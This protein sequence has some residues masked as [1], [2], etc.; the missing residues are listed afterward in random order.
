MRTSKPKHHKNCS[1][2]RERETAAAAAA[3]EAKRL[4]YQLTS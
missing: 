1:T 3:A 4:E 2:E